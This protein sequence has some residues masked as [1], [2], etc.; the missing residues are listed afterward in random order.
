MHMK[1]LLRL[2]VIA[3]VICAG[4]AAW[5]SVTLTFDDLSSVIG[6]PNA[7]NPSL[8]NG[9]VPTPYKGFN[10]PQFYAINK[11]YYAINF[12]ETGTGF[13]YGCVSGNIAV[14]NN[15]ANMATVDGSAFVFRS[16]YLTSG[17]YPTMTVTVNGYLQGTQ[18]YSVTVNTQETNPTLFAFPTMKVDTITFT[19]QYSDGYF[20]MDN[21]TYA[22]IPVVSAGPNVSVSSENEH[23]IVI[24]GTAGDGDNSALQYQWLDQNG[25]VLLG[26]TP[27]TSGHAYLNMAKVPPF[28]LGDHTLTL[29]VKATDT[30]G[31]IES[32]TMVLTV[33]YSSPHVTAKGGGR[34]D[35]GKPVTLKGTVSQYDGELLTWQWL[36]QNQNVLFQGQV[37]AIAGGQPVHIPD[38]TLTNVPIGTNTYTLSVS[39]GVNPPVTASVI[40]YVIQD[41][42][43]RLSPEA[44]TYLLWP[45]NHQMVPVTITANAYAYDGTPV[46]LAASVTDNE[47]H[48]PNAECHMPDVDWTTPVINQSTGTIT[49]NLRAERN[50]NGTGRDY[51]I[52][53][54][55]TDKWNNTASAAVEIKVGRAYF[56][57]TDYWWNYWH[58]T[59]QS[60][61]SGLACDDIDDLGYQQWYDNWYTNW[62]FSTQGYSESY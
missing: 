34:Y 32:S 47:P 8:G 17:T 37:Q 23:T 30:P 51:T 55:A 1:A 28:S 5:A 40:V 24:Q 50:D 15:W 13:Y 54:T 53:I 59:Y 29:Q 31:L 25:N 49:L 42:P 10:W 19:P 60:Q 4:N 3:L 56:S 45:P 9:P 43:P 33:S 26:W 36:D 58:T 35:V 21:F 22:S 18:V 20:V 2:L 11:N 27:V 16:A 7:N 46:T 12:G 57:D 39:D 62:F 38:E 61:W 52:T 6:V 41:I 14:Y 44:S 48:N